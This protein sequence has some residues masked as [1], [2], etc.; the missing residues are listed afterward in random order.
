MTE[1]KDETI[2]RLTAMLEAK[3]QR[4]TAAVGGFF[5][6]RTALSRAA[7]QWEKQRDGL[8]TAVQLRALEKQ[9][10]E[11]WN[12][13]TDNTAAAPTIKEAKAQTSNASLKIIAGLAF[14]CGIDI[15]KKGAAAQ[16]KKVVEAGDHVVSADSCERTI[17]AIRALSE[18]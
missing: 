17:R 5:A 7:E 9:V 6:V 8:A 16:M 15:A 4:E 13:R 12:I 2:K 11:Q 14:K 3:T 1:T 10:V 18:K